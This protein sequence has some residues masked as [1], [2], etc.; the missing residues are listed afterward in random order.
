MYVAGSRSQKHNDVLSQSCPGDNPGEAFPEAPGWFGRAGSQKGH[1]TAVGVFG[2]R[3][4]PSRL[5]E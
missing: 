1:P 5:N 4:G 3:V 2:K